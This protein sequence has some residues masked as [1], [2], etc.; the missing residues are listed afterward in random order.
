MSSDASE[1][2]LIGLDWGT[3]SF[4]AYLIASDGTI[5][6]RIASPEGILQVHGRD[7]DGTCERLLA[8]WLARHTPAMIASGMITSRN[9]WIETPYLTAPAG[10]SELASALAGHLT[11]SG[12]EIC[13]V[14]GLTV[15]RAGGAPD[16]MRGEE[17]QIVGAAAAGTPDGLFVTPGTHSKWSRARGG[18]IDGFATYMTGEIYAT[19]LAHSI[20][21]TLATEAPF[22]ESGFRAGVRAGLS[23]AESLL[24]SLFQVRTLPLFDKLAQTDVADY[25]SGLL[26]GTELRDALGRKAPA[27]AVTLIGESSLAQRYAVALEIAGHEAAVAADDMAARGHYV[28]AKAAGLVP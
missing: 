21:G 12:H 14:A 13:F 5:L 1:P 6:D 11:P 15:E 28:I 27:E 7:F 10:A 9:G 26:I 22:S 20:L 3:S 25:L 2:A 18:R 24:Y 8:P 4:R 16:V 19:L 23:T 17:T